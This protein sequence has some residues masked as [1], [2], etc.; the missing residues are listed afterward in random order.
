MAVAASVIVE[1]RSD[2]TASS[3]NGGGFNPS[4]TGFLTDLTTDSNTAN[5]NSP[6]CSS[7]SYNFV[8]GDVGHWLYIQSGTNWTA[9]W[10][11]IASVASNKA[12]LSAAVG[13]AEQITQ[14]YIYGVNTVA[15]CATV[16][17][18][19]NGTFTIDYSRGATALIASTDGA[20]VNG[21]AVLTSATG[22]FTPVLC[23][24]YLRIASG[25]QALVGYYEIIGYTNANTLTIDRDCANSSNMSGATFKVGGAVLPDTTAFTGL[26][27]SSST[28]SSYFF[29]KSGS[30]TI[31]AGVSSVPGGNVAAKC[32][33]EGY[34]TKRADKPSKSS[35]PVLSFGANNFTTG[36]NVW[37]ERVAI[38]GTNASVLTLGANCKLGYMAVTNTSTTASRV[39]I[40]LSGATAMIHDIEAQSYR[41]TAISSVVDTIMSGVYVHD[42]DIGISTNHSLQMTYSIVAGC[43]TKAVDSTSATRFYRAEN[44]T[45]YGFEDTLGT[46]LALAASVYLQF[47]RNCIFYGFATVQ[48]G[49]TQNFASYSDHNNYYNN[50]TDIADTS[51]WQK[52]PNDT[53]LDP[54]FSGVAQITGSTATTSGSTITQSGATFQTSGVTAG[55]DYLYL[56][57]GTGITAGIYGITS[58]DSET[59]LTL[60]IAPGTSATADKVW[61]IRVGSNFAIGTNLKAEGHPGAFAGGYSTGYVDIGAVQRQEQAGGGG[62][63]ANPI[64]GFIA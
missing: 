18:P 36:T 14:T 41:G 6:V 7:A 24:N 27:A 63:A 4:G 54:S 60:D 42:S 61:K 53:A 11:Q 28:I 9:G 44:C 13:E 55:R 51:Q 64:R 31:G 45:F 59:Q 52:G 23:G 2:A 35:W 26:S 21:S 33:I 19:T 17:T 62:L 1:M 25:T 8:A 58:V 22:G 40:T 43:V 12:T 5:T 37:I 48:D 38:T 3:V 39:A 15:G 50:D 16:G 56:V 47:W 34:G 32:R 46:G 29:I 20:S 57:S 30:Y 49:S 10:Y